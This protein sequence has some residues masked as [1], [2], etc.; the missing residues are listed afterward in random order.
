MKYGYLATGEGENKW[1]FKLK[2]KNANN[3]E[4]L[5]LAIWKFWTLS[6]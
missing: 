2:E 6:P 3:D 5:K 1:E 4:S